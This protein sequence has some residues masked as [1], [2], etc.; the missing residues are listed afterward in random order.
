MEA[1]L[2]I[3]KTVL[4]KGGILKCSKELEPLPQ[5]ECSLGQYL[6]KNLQKALEAGKDATFIVDGSAGKAS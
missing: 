1:L 2:N 5:L 4:G 6:V 3:P